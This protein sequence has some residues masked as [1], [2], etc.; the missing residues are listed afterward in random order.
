[1]VNKLKVILPSHVLNVASDR[2]TLDEFEQLS[3]RRNQYVANIFLILG[4]G[5]VLAVVAGGFL[6]TAELFIPLLFLAAGSLITFLNRRGAAIRLS[7]FIAVFIFGIMN[8][9]LNFLFISESGTVMTEV[10]IAFAAI[11]LLFPVYVPLLAFL[12][13]VLVENN[14]IMFYLDLPPVA[15]A[16]ANIPLLIAG[17][18]MLSIS[19]LTERMIKDLIQRNKETDAA[20]R[21]SESLVEELK[22][23][24]G[25]LAQFR[26]ELH[27]VIEVTN[28]TAETIDNRFQTLNSGVR[29]QADS[30]SDM[31][32]TLQNAN[33]VL[34][35]MAAE[36]NRMKDSS[37]DTVGITENGMSTIKETTTSMA[38]IQQVLDGMNE[39]M[40]ELK[41]QNNEIGEILAT[42]SDISSQTH[43]LALNAAIE[44][45]RAGEHGRGFAVVSTEI[46]KLAEHSGSST[47]QIGDILKAL[48]IRTQHLSDRFNEVKQSL[49]EGNSSVLRSEEA[50][51][52][53]SDF[54]VQTLERAKKVE[55][56]SNQVKTSSDEMVS[57]LNNIAKITQFTSESA[58]QIM[59]G[60]QQQRNQIEQ[61]RTSYNRLE[62]LIRNLERIANANQT[63]QSA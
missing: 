63:E 43:L 34:T 50:L 33:E 32:A 44:A 8:I 31:L 21:R 16:S 40:E 62:E 1:M 55:T 37:T 29:E 3:L 4:L 42:I 14:V 12:I 54:A 26:S 11:F 19:R 39:S 27:D 18:A 41:R 24:I 6:L 35:V 10:G 28:Q 47:A 48:Q 53:I 15:V 38:D 23:T 25:T 7:P 56:F 22:Q 58:E 57:E 30:I 36:S 45:A 49:M 46:R 51:V 13:V 5:N 52:H 61:V 59:S 9:G 60:V 17:V 2:K 20:K